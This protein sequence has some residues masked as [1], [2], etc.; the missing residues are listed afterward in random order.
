MKIEDQELE[1]KEKKKKVQAVKVGE[2][3]TKSQN[4]E[5]K[6]DDR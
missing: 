6:M 2:P 4:V 3:L 5:L 1:P